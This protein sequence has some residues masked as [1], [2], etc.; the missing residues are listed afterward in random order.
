MANTDFDP[1][2]Y[3][4]DYDDAPDDELCA[5]CKGR[6]T[7]NPLTAPDWFFCVGTTLCPDCDGSG[8]SD[9]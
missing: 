7:V 6:G 4:D 8:E 9:V 3:Q 2:D 1:I 5:T